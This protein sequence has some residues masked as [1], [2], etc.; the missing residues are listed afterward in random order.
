MRDVRDRIRV[1]LLVV[2]ALTHVR[3]QPDDG[4]PLGLLDSG[5]VLRKSNQPADGVQT[6]EVQLGQSLVTIAICR[7]GPRRRS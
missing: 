1:A 3:H 4:E 7:P 5:E 2:V 6:L